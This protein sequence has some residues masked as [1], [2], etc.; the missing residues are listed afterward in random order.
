MV[1]SLLCELGAWCW[2]RRLP[3][4]TIEIDRMQGIWMEHFTNRKGLRSDGDSLE[5]R[6]SFTGLSLLSQSKKVGCWPERGHKSL[7]LEPSC[8]ERHRHWYLGQRE[9]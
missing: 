6:S 9:H 7:W 4:R 5:A 1:E 8:G 3:R 2:P